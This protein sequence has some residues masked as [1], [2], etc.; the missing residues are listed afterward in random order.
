MKTLM[1]CMAAGLS[2]AAA[3]YAGVSGDL[4]FGIRG[5]PSVPRLSGGNN[6]VSRGYD[7]ILAPNGGLVSEYYLTDRFSLLV[8][9][10]YSGQGGERKGMQP[11]TQTP[12]GLPQLPPGQLLYGDF[13]NTSKLNYLEVP[14]MGKYEWGSGEHWRCF[15]ELGPYVGY[16]LD[17]K[18]ET[19]GTSQ[20]Y[21][22]KN[23]TPLTIEGNPLPAMSF[24]SDTNV[25]GDL[26]KW[27]VGIMGGIGTAYLLNPNNQVFLDL[28]GEYG[29]TTVQKDTEQN[30]KSHTGSAVLSIGYKFMFGR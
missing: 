26:N 14:V 24:D 25:R 18:E 22:D 8:E 10:D 13:K 9:V 2:M 19:R 3:S 15:A 4:W 29:L 6:D 17:A 28:R 20:I 21:V 30:G 7:S 5:G 27:N 12:D 16:L 23:G 1:A 11:I